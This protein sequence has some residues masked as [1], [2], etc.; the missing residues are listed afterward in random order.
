VSL[1]RVC[2]TCSNFWSFCGL[3]AA[4]PVMISSEL[5]AESVRDGRM[6][7]DHVPRGPTFPLTDP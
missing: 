7:A 2:T 5:H 4:S 6:R 3:A 1:S